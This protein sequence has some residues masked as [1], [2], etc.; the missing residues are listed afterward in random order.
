MTTI[1]GP[2]ETTAPLR[3]GLAQVLMAKQELCAVLSSAM[4]V[5]AIRLLGAGLTYASMVL[6][7]RWLGSDDFGIY[8]YVLVI[9]TLVGLAFSFG[10][11]SS[12]LRF[13]STYLAQNK[14]RRLAG[15][16]RES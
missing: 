6:L 7:A 1:D 13:I 4:R 16:L 2:I 12:S 5:F 15:F 10:F 14:L 11:N 9:I 3:Q 8:A